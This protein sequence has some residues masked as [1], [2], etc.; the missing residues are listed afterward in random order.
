M[1]CQWE[2][3]WGKREKHGH[4]ERT[5]NRLIDTWERGV[6]FPPSKKRMRHTKRQEEKHHEKDACMCPCTRTRARTQPEMPLIPKS[7]H[8][9][10]EG[11]GVRGNH[12]LNRQKTSQPSGSDQKR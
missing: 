10:P 1:G 4:P 12:F 6:R 7:R 11:D 2:L 9:D 5:G 3:G 8:R